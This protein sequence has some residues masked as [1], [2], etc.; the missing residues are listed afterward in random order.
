MDTADGPIARWIAVANVEEIQEGRPIGV[1]VAG[2]EVLL[3]RVGDRI[4]ATDGICSHMEAFL[5]EGTQDGYVITCPRHG[6]QFDIRTGEAIRL[7]AVDPIDTFPVQIRDGS[8]F[9]DES[10]L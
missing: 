6:G 4:W 7:P 3:C 8:V 2:R 9:L 5:A 1:S 10:L